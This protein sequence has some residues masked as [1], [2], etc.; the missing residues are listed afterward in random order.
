M[1]KEQIIDQLKEIQEKLY[2]KHKEVDKM[3]GMELQ[4]DN[5]FL[6]SDMDIGMILLIEEFKK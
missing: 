1:N 5:R 2:K 6:Y 4:Y 3:T